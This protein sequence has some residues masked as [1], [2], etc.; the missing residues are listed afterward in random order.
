MDATP[1]TLDQIIRQAGPGTTINLVPGTYG[2][3]RISGIRVDPNRPI[4]IEGGGATFNGRSTLATFGPR[5]AEIAREVRR[6]GKYPGVYSIADEA[7]F[8]VEHC[9]GLVFRDIRFRDAWPTAV[10]INDCRDLVFDKLDGLGATFFIYAVGAATRRLTISDCHWQQ[11]ESKKVWSEV[12]WDDIHEKSDPEVA[13]NYKPAR[14]YDGSFFCGVRIAGDVEIFRCHVEHAFNGVHLFNHDHDPKLARNVRVHECRFEFIK[15]NPIEPEHTACNWWI[16]DNWFFN[17]HKWFSMELL[18]A[19]WI[20]IY[21]NRGWFTEKPGP[22]G[23][24]NNGGAVF[25]FPETAAQV[26]DYPGPIHVFNNSWYLRSPI[27]KEGAVRNFHHYNNA[28]AYCEQVPHDPRGAC[29]DAGVFHNTAEPGAPPFTRDWRTLGI[30]FENDCVMHRDWPTDGYPIERALKKDPKFIWTGDDRFKL[31]P[32]SPCRDK[33]VVIT[34]PLPNGKAWTPPP[35]LNIGWD[36][37]NRDVF[38]GLRYEPLR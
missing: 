24:D 28:I 12:L 32:G 33:G 2:P 6:S 21:R 18:H 13:D 29:E 11:D 25:K 1:D 22:R 23:E 7:A 27:V 15:D 14:A 38:S 4:V 17:A 8:T 37:D 31:S 10:Y 36:Q 34:V 26:G 5:A 35:K 9:A 3:L 19:G 20:Y 16:H 30:R